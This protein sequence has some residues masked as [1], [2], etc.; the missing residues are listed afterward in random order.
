MATIS[1][2]KNHQMCVQLDY[3]TNPGCLSSG[4]LS[5]WADWW[6]SEVE[7][8]LPRLSRPATQPRI[9]AAPAAMPDGTPGRAASISPGS[10]RPRSRPRA[11]E[12]GLQGV[13]RKYRMDRSGARQRSGT[14]RWVASRREA[15]CTAA[16][17][18]TAP[19]AS[20]C[21]RF[22]QIRTPFSSSSSID[23]GPASPP[24]LNTI[25]GKT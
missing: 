8:R 4:R 22:N 6:P 13:A 7:G 19:P 5:L 1:F 17:T 9:S 18:P 11:G 2:L 14:C 3:A 12:T 23:G 15:T 24:S 16:H 20:S 21:A 25:P 10:S